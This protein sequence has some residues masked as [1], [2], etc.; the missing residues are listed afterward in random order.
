MRQLEVVKTKKE[1]ISLK[2]A[3][4]EAK[5]ELVGMELG[6]QGRK[7][8]EAKPRAEANSGLCGSGGER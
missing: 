3:I 4:D 7:L 2:I 1:K 5:G 8:A 6:G